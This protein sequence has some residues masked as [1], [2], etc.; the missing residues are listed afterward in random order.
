ML[1]EHPQDDFVL[2]AI[3]QEYLNKEQF[4]NAI[5]YFSKLKQK[6]PNYVG[7]YYHFAHALAEMGNHKEAFKIYDEGIAIAT[8]SGDTHTLSELKNAKMNLE[9]DL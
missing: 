7:L 9:L 8:Q 3:A 5:I 1:S 4:D 2:Y 6:N